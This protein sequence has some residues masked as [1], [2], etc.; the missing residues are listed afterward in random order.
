MYNRM[1]LGRKLNN[2]AR[3]QIP[4]WFKAYLRTHFYNKAGEDLSWTGNKLQLPYTLQH[5]YIDQIFPQP[6]IAI[7]EYFRI[8]SINNPVML[9]RALTAD[10]VMNDRL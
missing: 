8:D 1:K 7:S 3:Q 5:P 9:S 4:I 6:D 10:L 2:T